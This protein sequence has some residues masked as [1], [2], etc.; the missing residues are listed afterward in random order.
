[1]KKIGMV[2]VTVKRINLISNKEFDIYN[3]YIPA[4]TMDKDRS[5]DAVPEYL[6]LN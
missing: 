1:M 4:S 2:V 5:F 6:F 3:D